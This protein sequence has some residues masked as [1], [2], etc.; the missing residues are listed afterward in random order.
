MTLDDVETPA[1]IVDLDRLDRNLHRAADYA[2][3]HGLALRPHI[4]THKS[5]HVAKAQLALGASGLTCATPFETQVMS[6]VCDDLLNAFPPVGAERARRLMS[7]NSRI[8]LTVALDST[9]AV[10]MLH[11]AASVSGRR[12]RVYVELDVGMRRVGVANSRDAVALAAYVAKRDLL[13]YAGV[14]LYPG[15]I[16]SDVASQDAAV[17]SL[18]RDLS[19]HINAL[20]NAGLAPTTVSAGSTPTLWRSHEL[21]G[22]N[23]I[24]PGSYVYNDRTIASLGACGWDDCAMTVLATVVSTSVSGHAVID[25]GSKALGRE[26]MAGGDADGFGQLLGRPDVRVVRMSEEHGVLDLGVT[27]WRP[28]IGERVRVIP[29]H[30]CVAVSLFDLT[31]GV[32]DD[33]VE[34]SW[35]IDARGRGQE[36]I[37]VRPA[38]A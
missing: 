12:V 3:T 38:L 32:R 19:A 15:H 25:A 16:R 1:A 30:V 34:I 7:L 8:A 9:E 20:G 17:R 23:E 14:A 31:Y 11:T 29:N 5:L 6:V 24:R 36:P 37:P 33:E 26:P 35:R 27:K 21:P 28:A 13:E 22:V 10:D 18:A 2:S 4:K